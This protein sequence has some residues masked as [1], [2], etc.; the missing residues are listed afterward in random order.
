MQPKRVTDKDPRA[1]TPSAGQFGDF[2]E[3]ITILS[4]NA[5]LITFRTFL[6]PYE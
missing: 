3:K 5:V 1:K 6:K 4:F 2:A